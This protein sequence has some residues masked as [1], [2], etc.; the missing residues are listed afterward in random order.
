MKH[1]RMY[2]SEDP[3]E[4]FKDLVNLGIAESRVCICVIPMRLKEPLQGEIKIWLP[5]LDDIKGRITLRMVR[6]ELYT[7]ERIIDFYKG[8]NKDII[9]G[10][11]KETLNEFDDQKFPIA[12]FL[13]RFNARMGNRGFGGYTTLLIDGEEQERAV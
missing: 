13:R 4:L 8:W 9:E 2:E 10:K 7:E 1:L 12:E 5:G 6:D 3:H 11:I